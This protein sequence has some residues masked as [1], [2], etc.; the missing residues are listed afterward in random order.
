MFAFIGAVTVIF[1]VAVKVVAGLNWVLTHRAPAITATH[2]LS[3]TMARLLELI[4]FVPAAFLIVHDTAGDSVVSETVPLIR[5]PMSSATSTVYGYNVAL[6]M[7]PSPS[8]V[9]YVEVTTAGVEAP[10]TMDITKLEGVGAS[11]TLEVMVWNTAGDIEY[12]TDCTARGCTYGGA[13]FPG[14][15]TVAFAAM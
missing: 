9:V 13:T 5:A 4:D 3:V 7:Y 2:E 6:P 15:T 12:H 10:G 14:G 1:S 11:V 8:R